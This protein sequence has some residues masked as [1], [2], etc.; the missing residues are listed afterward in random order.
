MLAGARAL[1]LAI[2]DDLAVI[3]VDDIPAAR[4][5]APPLT[6]VAVDGAAIAAH[7]T[8]LITRRLAGEGQ[9]AGEPAPLAHLVTRAST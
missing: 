6:T 1:G 5:A 2:P 8:G 9:D 3:G 4:F 7:L